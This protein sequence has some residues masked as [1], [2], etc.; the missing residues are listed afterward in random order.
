MTKHVA[1]RWLLGA[2]L[3]AACGNDADSG[4]VGLSA[5]EIPVAYTPPGGYGDDFPEPVLARCT[6]PLVAGAP[7]L[8]GMWQVVGVEVN[9]APAPADHPAF[10]HFERVEQ[11]GDR[12]VVT[13][14]GIIHD[15][16]CDGTFENGVHDVL[17]RDYTTPIDVIAT[18]E[19]GVHVLRPVA[20]PGVE[21][22]RRRDGAQMIW[23]YLTFTARLE[24]LG[25]PEMPP[26][27]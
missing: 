15:M 4:S 5:S 14:G 8:R 26:P 6:E 19:D 1:L 11:C 10:A 12:L 2:A 16:R 13:A 18:Y 22:T 20:A 17:E 9:G 25:P 21:V 23:K 27:R 7:D 3:L 24:R